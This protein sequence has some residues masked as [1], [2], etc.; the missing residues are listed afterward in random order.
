MAPSPPLAHAPRAPST[1]QV[2]TKALTR[3]ADKYSAGNK[4]ARIMTY[5]RPT[6]DLL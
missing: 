1:W 3:T 5:L 2:I 6:D 4:Q